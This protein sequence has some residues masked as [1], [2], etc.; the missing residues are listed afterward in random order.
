MRTVAAE[1]GSAG[2]SYD[3]LW[4]ISVVTP[5]GTGADAVGAAVPVREIR[6]PNHTA[7]RGT[8]WP[9]MVVL[10]YTGME[11]AVSAITRLCD[12]TAEVS[13]HYVIAENGAV[14]LLVDETLRAWHA[15][16]ARWGDVVD[17]NSHAIG[18]EIA[19]PGQHLGYPPFPEPQMAAL[20]ALLAS[21][22]GRWR[23]LPERVVG[24]ACI[25]PGRK[26]DPGEKLD[27]RRLSLLG[28][29]IWLDLDP[30]DAADTQAPHDASRF[31]SAA[32]GIGYA[33]EMTGTW[34]EQTRAVWRAFAMRFLPGL[35]G[36]GPSR[37]LIRHAAR[38]A[39]A[40]PVRR[41]AE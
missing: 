36:A 40:W 7:R 22:L 28:L 24:H 13:A 37:G 11:C 16:R 41:A 1:I 6:S 20:D 27:W 39:R 26:I 3:I 32:R 5:P 23:I 29:A 35:A 38:I 21:I 12:P 2:R 19:N 30:A 8:E 18:I 9:D 34:D 17:V 33:V 4:T 25:A 10:H 31:Q 15:G 14:T